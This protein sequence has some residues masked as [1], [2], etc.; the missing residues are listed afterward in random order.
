M[1]IRRLTVA[2]HKHA[3]VRSF[4]DGNE[5]CGRPEWTVVV[6]GE[7]MI[8]DLGANHSPLPPVRHL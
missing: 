3:H 2:Q 8:F 6:H 4:G 1:N 7:R 5:L